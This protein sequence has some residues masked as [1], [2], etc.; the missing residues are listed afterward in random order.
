[1]SF[2]K[3]KIKELLCKHI[4][5]WHSTTTDSLGNIVEKYKFV[6]IKCSHNLNVPMDVIEQKED[7]PNYVS[8]LWQENKKM[9][10]I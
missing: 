4:Y 8:R 3:K 7:V 9:E 10:V 2:I 1:M 5:R 6:C